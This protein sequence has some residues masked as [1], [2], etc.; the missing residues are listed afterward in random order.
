MEQN[1]DINQLDIPLAKRTY[2]Y[3]SNSIFFKKLFIL[4]PFLFI[5]FSITGFRMIRNIELEPLNNRNVQAERNHDHRILGHLPYNEIPK[6]KLAL[7][8][9]NIEVHIDMRDSLLKM[10]EEAIKDGIYLVFLSGFRSI[11]LQNDI[12]YSLKSIRNQ[13]ASE[14][15]RVSAPPG[16]SE[17]STGF[18]IDIG[19]GTQRET[20][21]EIEFENTDAFR[22]LIKNAAKYHFKLSFNKNNKYI[23]YE[24]WHWRY[25]GS[26]EA[27]K[28]FET[29]NR[30]L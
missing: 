7:I 12:F 25:E 28:I 11:N 18:A 15:A 20:D 23:D 16:Y 6:N 10:R 30:E 22:W 8:E 4:S 1:K 9:P 29:S 13:E 14:R 2:L 5:L 21:F 24:P 19:D 27:L 3:K 17:H 26:I